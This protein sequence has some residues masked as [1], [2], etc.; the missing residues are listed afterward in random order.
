MLLVVKDVRS[1]P[2][3]QLADEELG[4]QLVVSGPADINFAFFINP[5]LNIELILDQ[6]VLDNLMAPSE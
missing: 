2:G 1:S 5:I 3:S 4:T 6:E